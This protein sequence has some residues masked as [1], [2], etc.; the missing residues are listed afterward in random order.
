MSTEIILAP[1]AEEARRI[2]TAQRI[3]K[4]WGVSPPRTRTAYQGAVFNRLTDDWPVSILSAD[5]A[6][7]WE[8]KTL[9]ARSRDLERNGG[10]AE[11]YG[12]AVE[13]NIIGP[14]GVGLQMKA[15]KSDART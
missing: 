9:R 7:R 10:I 6:T 2:K 4:T 1:D 5:A 13:M 12:S 3:A 8:L 11:R 15:R 14:N